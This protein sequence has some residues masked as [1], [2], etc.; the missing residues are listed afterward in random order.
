VGKVDKKQLLLFKSKNEESNKKTIALKG[1]MRFTSNEG[2]VSALKHSESVNGKE[3]K[4][5]FKQV[6]EELK[7]EQQVYPKSAHTRTQA[8][9]SNESEIK[10]TESH[11]KGSL[12]IV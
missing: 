5:Q 3:P 9:Q 4:K 1:L 12:G 10:Q 11:L 6:A 8:L 2:L 7:R